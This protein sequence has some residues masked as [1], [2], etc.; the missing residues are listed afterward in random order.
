[1]DAESTPLPEAQLRVSTFDIERWFRSDYE[2]V[3]RLISRVVRD[4]G[5]AQELAAEVFWRLSNTPAAQGEN[6]AGWVYRTATRLALDDLRKQLR[7]E[8]YE[9]LFT[10]ARSP[11]TPEELYLKHEDERQVRVVLGT[12]QKRDSELLLLRSSDFSYEEIAHTLG[13]NPASI[14]TLLR[15]AEQAFRKEYVRRNKK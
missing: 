7:R 1:M 13:L 3:S 8:K 9:H 4:D 12:L 15:R 2:R 14:G 6:T 11:R 5:R 10:I